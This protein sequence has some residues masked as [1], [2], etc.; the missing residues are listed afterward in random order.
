M[1]NCSLCNSVLNDGEATTTYSALQIQDA[2]DAGMPMPQRLEELIV[3]RGIAREVA[4]SRWVEA[5]KKSVGEWSV[6]SNC[7]GQ[8]NVHTNYAFASTLS[9]QKSEIESLVRDEVIT[10]NAAQA[11][12]AQQPE[13]PKVE[14]LRSNPDY[15]SDVSK[16]L[17]LTEAKL[18]MRAAIIGISVGIVSSLLIA[19][20]A[21]KESMLGHVFSLR[22][23]STLIPVAIS[24]MF[25]W[26][27]AICWFRWRRLKELERVSSKG[28]LLHSTRILS[29][30]G[31]EE[32]S[33]EVE[34][35]ECQT[36]PLLRRLQAVI[37][38]WIT[39]PNLQDADLI[40][41]QHI[42]NDE[43]SVRAG[44]NLV[45]TFIWA[46][47]VLGLIGTV[48]G[49]SLAVGGFAQFL[50]TDIDDVAIIKKNLVG[51]T[52]GLSYAFLITLH[53]LLTAL[54]TMLV[55]SALQLREER[56]YSSVEQN[57]A[58]TFLP[59]LQKE[60][61]EPSIIVD[62]TTR[63]DVRSEEEIEAWRK[64]LEQTAEGVLA[65]VSKGCEQMIKNIEQR[66]EYNR[67][68][69][70]LWADSLRQETETSAARFGEALGKIG[71]D[72]NKTGDEFL[73]R[74]TLVRGAIDK[75]VIKW[76]EMMDAQT[77]VSSQHHDE[78]LDAIYKQ[79]RSHQ[80]VAEML[81]GLTETTKQALEQQ[82]ALQNA[83]N[84]L[85]DSN[86]ES[87]FANL[88]GAIAVQTQAM[89]AIEQ[90]LSNMS[91]NTSDVLSSQATLQKAVSQLHDTGFERTLAALTNSLTSLGP[92]LTSFRE[93]FVLQAVPI[94]KSADKNA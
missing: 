32:L 92:V 75:Q 9:L 90:T 34:S 58:D 66:D 17:R 22:S 87:H 56:L 16:S 27:I 44:Y 68:Q 11:A 78:M 82:T 38:Q 4:R 46:L 72:M 41:Q 79:S 25:F 73:N 18:K 3:T 28:L 37:K 26:A 81:T 31:I 71:D 19:L 70:L 54:I 53:G 33:K 6:C 47:P 14:S 30:S 24:C 15:P 76:R 63:A 35:P 88:A 21:K 65:S 55:A 49:I 59:V 74:L 57:I 77:Q 89:Q 10:S 83:I 13:K 86:L 45:R 60:A 80:F 64:T 69:S 43:E 67:G 23:L 12:E 5:I 94:T 61:P 7:A 1:S 2:V 29:Q 91:A 8:I 36:S 39:K 85:N 50:A 20:I 40:L 62:T 42:A 48:I 52:G 84:R 93:P 51:V